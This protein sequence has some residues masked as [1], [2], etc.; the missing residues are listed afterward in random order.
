MIRAAEITLYSENNDE[1]SIPLSATQLQG[2]C[3]LLGLKFE[4]GQVTCF[5]DS[6]LEKFMSLTIDKW[7][8]K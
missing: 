3:K 6:S 8:L 4:E 2:I 7:E 5:S 1:I